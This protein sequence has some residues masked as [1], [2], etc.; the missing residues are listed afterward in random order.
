[1]RGLGSSPRAE[2]VLDLVWIGRPA[3]S[4]GDEVH[5]ADALISRIGLAAQIPVG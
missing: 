1:M 2:R 5:D 3:L 4:E